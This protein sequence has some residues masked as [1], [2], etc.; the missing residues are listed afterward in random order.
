MHLFIM[1]SLKAMQEHERG[2]VVGAVGLSIV[3]NESAMISA[4]GA[5]SMYRRLEFRIH[6]VKAA[7]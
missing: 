2:T 6:V 5:M 3:P 7:V 1:P 4:K